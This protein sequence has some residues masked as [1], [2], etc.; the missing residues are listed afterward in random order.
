VFCK[1]K[2]AGTQTFLGEVQASSSEDALERAVV[3][4]S[5]ERK[6]LAWWIFPAQLITKSKPDE[7]DSLYAPAKDKQFR[8]S[9]DF[10]TVSA[11]RQIRDERGKAIDERRR[12]VDEQ[13]Q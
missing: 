1:V 9:T 11:M 2:E 5:Q 4:Y 12:T 6:P 8:M 10:H 13:R 3:K 7:V